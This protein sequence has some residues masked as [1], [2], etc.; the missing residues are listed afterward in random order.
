MQGLTRARRK[1]NSRRADQDR[2][3]CSRG[4][5]VQTNFSA[6]S[7]RRTRKMR[8]DGMVRFSSMRGE[9]RNRGQKGG[10]RLASMSG[11]G[12]N[13][14]L[15]YDALGRCVWR[16]LN[17]TTIYYTYDGPHPIYER[18]A[19]GT[20]AGWNLYGQG[21]DEIL[22]RADYQVLSNGQGYFFQQNRIGSVTHLTGF[23]G[24][25][26]EQYRYDAFGT[27][28]TLDPILG[29]FNNRFKFTGREYQEAFGIYEYRNRAY[30]PGL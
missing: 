8:A 27:P 24:E 25:V 23:S 13:Y 12:N 3:G 17:G 19:H 16:N 9:K 10:Q 7:R 11:N 5:V 28:T 15:G 22:L 18:K 6:A 30:H 14:A 20:R 21:I 2:S 26:I 29:Y 4:L 1:T